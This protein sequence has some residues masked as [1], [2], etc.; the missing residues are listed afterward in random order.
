MPP[1]H[2]LAG[3][4]RRWTYHNANTIIACPALLGQLQPAVI[5]L[6]AALHRGSHS[7]CLMAE[8]LEPLDPDAAATSA[9][10]VDVA[11]LTPLERGS[12]FTGPGSP[13]VGAARNG[14]GSPLGMGGAGG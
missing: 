1:R 14:A 6:V 7:M 8:G 12:A 4:A 5:R 3:C 2:R 13:L 9:S 10:G 11:P